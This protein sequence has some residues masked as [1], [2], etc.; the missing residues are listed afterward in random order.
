MNNNI[1]ISALASAILLAVSGCGSDSNKDKKAVDTAPKAGQVSIEGAKQWQPM[2]AVLIAHD[3]DG[4]AISLT[5]YEDGEAVSGDNGVYNFSHGILELG[6]DKAMAYTSL[7]GADAVIN[8][9]VTANGKTSSGSITISGVQGDPLASEQWHLHNRAQKAFS[10]SDAFKEQL[11][12]LNGYQDEEQKTDYFAR[13]DGYFETT[14]TAGEDMN[15]LEAYKLGVTGKGTIAVV[16]DQGVEIGHEDLRDNVLA[17]RSLNLREGALDPTN[18]T[19][20]HSKTASHGTAVAGLI[21]A[22]AHNGIGG[23]GVA[24]DA[25][26]ISINYLDVQDQ[27]AAHI[28]SLISGLPASGIQAHE[29]VVFN[30]SYG[31]NPPAFLPEDPID[32]AN[33][34]YATQVLRDGKG[35]LSINAAGNDFE[36]GRH[37]GNYCAASGVNDLGLSCIDLNVAQANRSLHNVSVAALQANGQRSSYSIAG[38]AM[39]ISAPGGEGGNWEPAMVTTD[40]MTCLEGGSS[41]ASMDMYERYWGVPASFLSGYFNFDFPGHPMN[42]NCHYTTQ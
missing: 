24:P 3:Q 23:R 25:G 41:L 19:I 31:Y 30:R 2:D 1:K 7:S 40:E 28:S 15:V 26:L 34:A 21:A 35:A 4:D 12:W 27:G 29:N 10:Q 37:N 16:V 32:E 11:A 42:P 18:P 17:F 6:D 9:D 22:K 8:Y 39:F 5:F 33:M 20:T 36:E 14:R 13:L 38:S